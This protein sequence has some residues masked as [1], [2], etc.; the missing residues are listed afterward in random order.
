MEE[1][2]PLIDGYRFK[3]VP[4]PHQLDHW[5]RHR[6]HAA[7][8][9]LWEPGTGKSKPSIDEASWKFLTGRINGMLI[10]APGGVHRNWVDKE[11]PE[12]MPDE[13]REKTRV[14]WYSGP[15]HS[16]KTHQQS[17]DGMF[18]AGRDE[19][20]VLAMSWDS[21]MT[22]HGRLA[23][24]R[25]LSAR[26]TC[27]IC[28]ES[29]VIKN[30]NAKVTKRAVAAAKY[31][32]S[33][34]I[35]NGTPVTNGPFD[36]YSQVKALDENFW[37]DRGIGGFAEFKTI[38]A[39]YKPITVAGGKILN[40]VSDYRNLPMLK[41]YVDELCS[42]VTKE[43][44]LP[45]L[46]PKIFSVRPFEMSNEQWRV[47]R[48]LEKEFMTF[49]DG[50]MITAEMALTRLLRLHQV[51][52]GY[53]P[54]SD[55]NRMIPI[56]KSNPGLQS[57]MDFCDEVPHSAIIWSRFRQSID[58][59]CQSLGDRAVRYDGSVN[60]DDRAEAIRKFQ[61]GEVQ[62]FVANAKA[63][64]MGLTLHRAQSVY[65]ESC[66][67]NLGDRLQ[68]EDRAHRIGQEHPVNY[69]DSI[70]IGTVGEKIASSLVKK[71][72]IACQLTGDS[73][74]SWFQ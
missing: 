53:L 21:L 69:L 37:K 28:D 51:T 74:R 11:I 45:W 30:M 67:F 62:F 26:K 46:P 33:R 1:L 64:G 3:T 16:T 7:R 72:D 22:E 57:L 49:I 2:P 32:Q 4:Y 59:I 61:A 5:K 54:S 70:A 27:M 13:V 41:G 42:R 18:S 15:R 10:L 20:A 9:K 23:A 71:L 39:E 8:G 6:D 24:W 47:Y 58:W 38:F 60:E 12:H 25:M 66:D 43:D 44:V 19:L 34:M 50:D 40:V 35:L 63:A 29:K 56:G 48:D 36:L 52:C 14:H 31:A 73:R 65:I 17:L 68:L 55:E